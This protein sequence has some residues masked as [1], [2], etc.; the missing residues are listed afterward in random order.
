MNKIEEMFQ[1]RAIVR[2]KGLIV[3]KKKDAIDFVRACES[4]NV[5][6]LGIDGF[7]ISKNKIQP[8]IEHSID[9]SSLFTK[10]YANEYHISIEF[11][12]SRS[13]DMFFE[14][15]CESQR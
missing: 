11:L 10:K 12:Q 15:V 6:I 5:K 13:D 1:D 9:F 4:N 8:S 2:H 3:Y 7:F 14:I